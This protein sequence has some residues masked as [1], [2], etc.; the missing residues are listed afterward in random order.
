MINYYALSHSLIVLIVYLCMW[1]QLISKLAS[2]CMLSL[3]Q[4][5]PNLLCLAALLCS[6]TDTIPTGFNQTV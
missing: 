5:D 2:Y 6:A 4:F 1:L 3:T